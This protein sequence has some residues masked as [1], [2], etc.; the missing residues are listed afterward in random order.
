MICTII[1]VTA[2]MCQV[3]CNST[4]VEVCKAGECKDLVITIE[5]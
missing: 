1:Y 5:Q 2:I 4:G 3:C